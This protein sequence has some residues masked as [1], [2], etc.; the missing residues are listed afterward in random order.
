MSNVL[1]LVIPTSDTDVVP[2]L[3]RYLA[4]AKAG[5]I[6]RLGVVFEKPG[7]KWGSEF[8]Y[9]EDARGDAAMLME[10]AMRRLGFA[11]K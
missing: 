10:L 7:G 4:Q 11:L 3:E 6:T 1:E 2:M 5:E 9:S 8:S